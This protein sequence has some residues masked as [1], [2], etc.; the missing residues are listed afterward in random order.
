MV[1]NKKSV[2]PSNS[3]GGK[4]EETDTGLIWVGLDDH[5]GEERTKTGSVK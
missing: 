3:G 4:D 2:Q 5:I 1:K